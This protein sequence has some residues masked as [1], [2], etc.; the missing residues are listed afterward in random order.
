MNPTRFHVLILTTAVVVMPNV[1]H[2]ENER[3]GQYWYSNYCVS[4]HGNGG[5]GDGPVAKVLTKA[6]ADLTK[7]SAANG[8]T[9][10]Y[11]HVYETVD[12]THEVEAHGTREMPV[13]GRAVRFAPG[14]VRGRI[15][16]IVNHISTLQGK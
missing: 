10:P 11:M 12:G 1:A 8:G 16:A 15:R 5:K 9:F 6:P 4:C 13:W 3:T 7:L 14:I 2:S